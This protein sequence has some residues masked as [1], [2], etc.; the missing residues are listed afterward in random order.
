MLY[1]DTRAPRTTT[2]RRAASTAARITATSSR[3]TPTRR[4]RRATLVHKYSEVREPNLFVYSLFGT[5]RN[6][7]DR[8]LLN[9]KNHVSAK[10]GVL[11]YFAL[12]MV[13]KI[14]GLY[15]HI[16][17]M[18]NRKR[19]IILTIIKLRIKQA[20]ASFVYKKCILSTVRAISTTR[21][22]RCNLTEYSDKNSPL[23]GACVR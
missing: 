8:E 6:L 23:Q 4:S 15:W 11:K 10:T 7:T 14:A 22:P 12:K 13:L 18:S 19:A 5:G 2:A 16:I 20:S 1:I 17:N 21:Y 9:E 3:N